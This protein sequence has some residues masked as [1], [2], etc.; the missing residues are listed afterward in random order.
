MAANGAQVPDVRETG[1]ERADLEEAAEELGIEDVDDL[2]DQALLERIGVEL[3]EVDP[4]EGDVDDASD[5]AEE[6]DA[7]D[8]ADDATD[9]AEDTDAEDTADDAEDQAEE[10]TD[11]AEDQAGDEDDTSMTPAKSEGEYRFEDDPREGIE[12]VLDLELG[13]LALDVLGV[14]VHLKRVH[15]VLTA[16]PN[17]SHNVIGKLLA[18]LARAISSGGDEADEHE[19]TDDADEDQDDDGGLLHKATAPARGLVR[20]IKNTF[21]KD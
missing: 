7:E 17:G 19:D 4:D 1:L 20:G 5:D 8:T 21:D 2:D 15:A 14:E 18:G 10:P 3:G 13:P 16:N 11:D 12:P 6:T 9:D